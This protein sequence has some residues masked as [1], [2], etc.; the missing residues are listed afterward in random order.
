MNTELF[1]QKAEALH[2]SL[3]E[4]YETANVLHW[5]PTDLLPQA[6]RELY[7]TSKMVQLAIKEL[8]E[9]NEQLIQTRHLLETEL[10]Y[11]QHL[12]EFAPDAYLLTNQQGIIQTANHATSRLLNIPQDSLIGNL[13]LNYITI[14]ERALFFH[15]LNQICQAQ[16]MREIYLTMRTDQGLIFDAAL[17]ASVIQ[18]NLDQPLSLCW[19]IRDISQCKIR[20]KIL[21][22]TQLELIENRL[23]N[24]YAKGE[25]IFLNPLLILYV[26]KGI[27]KLT[28]FCDSG[29]EII[30]GLITQG[31]VLGS[32][33][34]SLPVYQATALSDVELVSIDLS[35]IAN[36]PGLSHTLLP[37]IQQ[38]L[39]QTQSFLFISNHR[40]IEERLHHF[41][42]LLKQQLGEKVANG[43]RINIRL[44]HEDIANAC[45]TTRVT[46]TRLISKLQQAGIINF[47]HKKHIILRD[48]S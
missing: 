47:D 17:T 28:T 4:L 13:L 23:L 25:N 38:R 15:E 48:L 16:K 39:Q 24:K 2:Q 30:T 12:F 33:L 22:Q 46:I 36:S 31:M 43:T 3:T 44:T 19:S 1:L 41:L 45:G 37:K 21:H 18:S 35:E 7:T 5:I 9:Q 32:S 14:E 11:Y 34:T 26:C 8:Y 6:F 27:V 40:K 42:Q 20:E 29:E 10:K